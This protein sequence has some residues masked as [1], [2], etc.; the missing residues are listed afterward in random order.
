MTTFSYTLTPSISENL[1]RI[2][3]YRSH[4]LTTAIPPLI[5]QK[6]RWKSTI[7]RIYASLRLA[8]EPLSKS[9]VVHA[10]TQTSNKKTTSERLIL[11]YRRALSI[12]YHDWSANPEQIQTK[13]FEELLSIIP[14]FNTSTIRRSLRHDEGS[15]RHVLT[16]GETNKDHPILLAGLLYGVCRETELGKR[17]R[18]LFPKLITNLI[19]AKFGYDCRGM[20]AYEPLLLTQRDRYTHALQSITTHGQFT[21]WLEHFTAIVHETY[22]LLYDDILASLSHRQTNRDLTCWELN[23]REKEILVLLEH[24][25]AKITNREVQHRFRI[26]QVTASRNLTHLTRVGLL[27]THGKGRSVYYTKV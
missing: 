10:L 9:S 21:E 27:Y 24:P 20:L 15:I 23:T 26:S 12:I 7:E 18:N 11:G 2:D 13:I 3:Q 19:V 22:A 8:S 17:T 25:T 1:R 6:L 4:I 14:E 16:Y 5:E